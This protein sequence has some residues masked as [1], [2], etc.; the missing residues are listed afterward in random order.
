MEEPRQKEKEKTEQQSEQEATEGTQTKRYT[1]KFLLSDEEIKAL[2][3]R[4]CD[5][6]LFRRKHY[7]SCFGIETWYEA[8]QDHTFHTLS[9]P[10]SVEEA[11]AIV[12]GRRSRLDE[13]GRQLL[14]DLRERLHSLLETEF[15]G[16]A[17]IKLDTRSPKDVPVYD[18]EN[19]AVQQLIRD[20]LERLYPDKQP[21]VRDT[22]ML[23][24]AIIIG[25]N[26]FMKVTN[27]EEALNLLIRSDRVK[28]DLVR[29]LPYRHF[30]WTT[31]LIL[32]EWWD[33][34]PERPQYEF[35]CFVH[36]NQLNAMT[37]YFSCCKCKCNVIFLSLSLSLS[38]I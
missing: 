10:L 20:E 9:V 25:T 37:Q 38:H 19:E 23:A 8:L 16:G 32:R 21:S 26:R 36:S 11:E 35:R 34:V 17:F 13:G 5:V 30:A 1:S 24:N 3:V 22:N 31:K 2:G 28:E 7:T 4:A 14:D 29:A 27:G 12:D 18:F 33:E 15:P 6:E